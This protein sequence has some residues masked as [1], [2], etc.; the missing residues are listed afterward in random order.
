MRGKN[1]MELG[2]YLIR[3]YL[4][5]IPGH[6]K[7][8]FLFGCIQ[9]DKNPITYLKGSL[10]YQWFRGHNYPNTHRFMNRISRRLEQ[11]HRLRPWDYYTLGKLI[12]YTSDAFTAAHNESCKMSLC[13]HR[14]Y[15]VSLQEYFL[16]YLQRCSHP[17]IRPTRTIM[18]EI[19]SRHR[20]YRSHAAS[21]ENDARF[22]LEACC[23]VLAALLIPRLMP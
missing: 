4:S 12:H 13:E 18:E 21:L 9:P 22:A 20:D 6:H 10:R 7:A 19:I 17:D 16:T 5:E 1:H 23:C 3:H 2:C 11:K 8:A 14:L 15:E